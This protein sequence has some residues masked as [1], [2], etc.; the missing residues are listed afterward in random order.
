MFYQKKGVFKMKGFYRALIIFQILLL[1]NLAFAGDEKKEANEAELQAYKTK[2]D[3]TLQLK[4][5]V[6]VAEKIKDVWI[7]VVKL[8]QAK[9]ESEAKPYIEKGLQYD[10]FNY[11]FQTALSEILKKEG[12]LQAAYKRAKV[13]LEKCED[14]PICLS[15][16]EVLD[17]TG[18]IALRPPEK[19]DFE[20]PT[21]VFCNL[22]EVN[23]L[24]ISELADSTRSYLKT[25]VEVY[26]I[27]ATL[28]ACDRNMFEPNIMKLQEKY[29]KD[30]RFVAYCEKEGIDLQKMGRCGYFLDAVVP[31]LKKET[32]VASRKIGYLLNTMNEMGSQWENTTLFKCL[33]DATKPFSGKNWFLVGV[34]R[35]DLFSSES[36]FL[37]GSTIPKKM[38]VISYSHFLASYNQESQDRPRLRKRL[39]KQF[40]SSFGLLLGLERCSMPGCARIYP[41]S[42]SDLDAKS[43]RLCAD[44]KKKIE[45]ILK[46]QIGD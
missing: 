40:L 28:P 1:T 11:A 25:P 10:P 34:T 27:V 4:D 15:A 22:G 44:C 16:L 41:N 46:I 7:Y 5:N 8:L 14:W 26:N 38:A 42:L 29:V 17:A 2:A 31:F 24:L 30:G 43:E 45:D 9:R 20:R 39:F 3:Q 19:K 33:S 18:T 36:N 37:F 35:Y 6:Q 12:D 13:A 32:D 21:I 23:P